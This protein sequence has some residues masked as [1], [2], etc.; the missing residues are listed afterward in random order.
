MGRH[1]VPSIT[2]AAETLPVGSLDQFLWKDLD[3]CLPLVTV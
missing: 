3:R 2:P 1:Y